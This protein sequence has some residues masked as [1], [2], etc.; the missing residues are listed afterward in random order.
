VSGSAAQIPL[1]AL[2]GHMDA[3][4]SLASGAAGE[5]AMF[6]VPAFFLDEEARD[7]FP[8]L[9]ARGEAAM[10]G[11]DRLLEAIAALPADRPGRSNGVPPID[12]TLAEVRRLAQDYSDLVRSVGPRGPKPRRDRQTGSAATPLPTQ[13]S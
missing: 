11:V 2:L 1:P 9:I 8:G 12:E 13:A 5:A 7:T 4:V 10:V 6:G 3:L